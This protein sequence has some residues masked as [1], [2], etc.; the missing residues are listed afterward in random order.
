MQIMSRSNYDRDLSVEH[1]NK[2]RP[3]APRK[4]MSTALLAIALLSILSAQ[5]SQATSPR[6]IEVT[7][8]RFDFEPAEITVKAGE[9][10][11][12]VL[13]TSDVPHGVRFRELNVELKA[14][15][16][17]PAEAQFTASKVGTFVGHCS[18]FCGT[19]HG[20]MTLTIHV[21]D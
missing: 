2:K 6:R 19:G 3:G 13:N 8:K 7:A 11:E 16:G 9:S 5:P 12:L 14:A 21:V 10:I 15:K 4:L 1:E 17:K 20:K 18:V